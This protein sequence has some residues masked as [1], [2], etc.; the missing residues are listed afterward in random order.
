MD[1]VCPLYISEDEAHNIIKEALKKKDT[2][3][4]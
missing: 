4:E 3:N 2:K 1:G